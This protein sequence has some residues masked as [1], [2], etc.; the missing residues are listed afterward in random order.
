M[1]PFVLHVRSL[2]MINQP[3]P[4]ELLSASPTEV[5]PKASL[6]NLS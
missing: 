1:T 4:Y 3:L 2:N 6:T 5:K